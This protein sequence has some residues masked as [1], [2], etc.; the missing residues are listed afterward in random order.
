MS[1]AEKTHSHSQTHRLDAVNRSRDQVAPRVMLSCPAPLPEPLRSEVV[2]LLA[3]M[4]VKDLR[5]N[6]RLAPQP[7]LP[8]RG[9]TVN[10]AKG[11]QS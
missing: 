9:T 11:R 10:D 6:P 3:R 8:E 5:E 2:E 7:S 4:L 1:R